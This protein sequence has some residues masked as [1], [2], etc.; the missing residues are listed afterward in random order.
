MRSLAFDL[1]AESGRAILGTLENKHLQLQE[2]HRFLNRPVWVRGNF[3]WNTLELWREIKEGLRLA[4]REDP[5]IKSLGIDT[6]GVDFGLL[7]E[8]GVLLGNP[9]H[10]RDPQNQLGYEQ[11]LAEVGK[12]KI[13]QQTGIQF[14]VFNSLY[15][16]KTLLMNKSTALSA[17]KTLLF[18]PDLFTY[19]LTG[20][21]VAEY[22]IA[23][24]SSMLSHSGRT[25][26]AELLAELGLPTDIFPELIQPGTVVGGLTS[27][28]QAEVGG[29]AGL[30]VIAPAEHDT[31]SAVVA[32]PA[33]EEDYAYLSCGTWS[34]LGVE[35]D[36]PVLS[37][38][39]ME[40]S[41]TNE[42][43]AGGKIRLLKNIMGL[44]L[45]QQSRRRWQLEGE[46]YSYAELTELAEQAPAFSSLI[47]PDAP[48]FLNPPSMPD[49]IC[50]FCRETGQ[51]VPQSKGEIS[52]TIL[53]SLA[54]K[55]R[56]TMDRLREVTGMK[57]GVL[58]MV[59]GGIQNKLLCQFAANA[60]GV[61]VVAGPVEATAIGNLMVQAMA[62]GE[63]DGLAQAREIVAASFPPAVYLPQ[64]QSAWEKQYQRF[65]TLLK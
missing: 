8:A 2:I 59:G 16:L 12:E 50:Q 43:G 36:Q 51:Y 48:E 29:G 60:C 10:Y 9:R 19:F 17:A 18:M 20:R 32:V 52:R 42:G 35:T 24:T 7:D 27:D 15:Q 41:L 56:W 46:N 38:A 21:K 23:S 40:G 33:E 62:L 4:L 26:A 58:H 1:G 39:A 22:T 63:V 53:E 34:L 30:Q 65:L 55:Y 64:D 57:L 5:E 25:F 13:W 47:D 31:A 28:V 61:K 3:Y 45:L 44:W 49:A 54:L 11:A 14:Q 37:P 6:W